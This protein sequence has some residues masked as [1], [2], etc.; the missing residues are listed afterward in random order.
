MRSCLSS[1][2][3]TVPAA[4][5]TPSTAA[6]DPRQHRAGGQAVAQAEAAGAARYSGQAR[7]GA[8]AKSRTGWLGYSK[9]WQHSTELW[10]A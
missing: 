2:P 9:S 1:C 10:I 6:W 5:R 4:Q 8:G 7:A 3:A